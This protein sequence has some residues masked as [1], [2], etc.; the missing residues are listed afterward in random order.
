MKFNNLNFFKKSEIKLNV[1]KIYGYDDN[2][3]SNYSYF[4]DSFDGECL[5]KPDIQSS[6]DDSSDTESKAETVNPLDILNNDETNEIENPL[7]HTTTGTTVDQSSSYPTNISS[8]FED[9]L[10]NQTPPNLVR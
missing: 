3:N 9:I 8:I 5:S 10:N 6:E 4:N 1:K 2:A 7:F